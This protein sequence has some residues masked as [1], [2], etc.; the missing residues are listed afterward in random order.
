MERITID[1]TRD[2]L[3][4][5]REAVEHKINSMKNYFADCE[6]VSRAVSTVTVTKG[7]ATATVQLPK[8][9]EAKWGL[10]KDGTPRARPGRKSV[11]KGRA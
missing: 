8:P 4:F 10:K 9:V 7:N 2:E 3:N 11:R 5:I 6:A 1:V